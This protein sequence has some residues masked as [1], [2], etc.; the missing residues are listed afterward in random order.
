[1]I[2]MVFAVYSDVHS[3]LEALNGF[4]KALRKIRFDK[5]VCLGD[6]VGYGADPDPVINLI[7]KKTDIILGGNHDFAVVGKTYVSDFNPYAFNVCMW[8][9]N[10]L[11]HDNFKFL[12]SLE[13]KTRIDG[14]TWAHSSPFEPE[15]WHYVSPRSFQ[16][17]NFKSF[18]TRVCFVGHS[19][20]PVILEKAPGSKTRVILDSKYTLKPHCKYIVNAGSIGQPRDGNPDP[21]FV[22]YNSDT[23]TIQFHRFAYDFGLAQEKILKEDLPPYLAERLSQGL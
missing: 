19:H 18:F 21:T 11:S 15:E 16:E 7:R 13:A 22:I 14:V 1:M 6:I 17:E 9:R 10:R 5:L 8:T 2:L 4:F 3:N 20:L 12:E 23:E